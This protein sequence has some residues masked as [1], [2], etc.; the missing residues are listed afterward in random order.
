MRLHPCVLGATF[1]EKE[2]TLTT[3]GE[4]VLCVYIQLE[5]FHPAVSTLSY[6]SQGRAYLARGFLL[7][8][9]RHFSLLHVRS[10]F[11]EGFFRHACCRPDRLVF[12]QFYEVNCYWFFGGSKQPLRLL[13]LDFGWIMLPLFYIGNKRIIKF[14]RRLGKMKQ[15][16]IPL[17]HSCLRAR[18]FLR[19]FSHFGNILSWLYHNYV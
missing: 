5:T 18:D 16:Q 14:F 6:R 1:E 7:C 2:R 13:F 4:T 10:F 8:K 15:W 11:R 9:S 19:Y 3:A 12:S 17:Y